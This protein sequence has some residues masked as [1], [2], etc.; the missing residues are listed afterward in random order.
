MTAR[1]LICLLALG[2]DVADEAKCCVMT[3]S[4]ATKYKV[5]HNYVL[6]G[7]PLNQFKYYSIT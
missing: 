1:G 4:L 5:L 6:H 7:D 2:E 3:I